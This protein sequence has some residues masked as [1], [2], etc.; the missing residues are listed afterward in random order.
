[1]SEG[2]LVAEI[3]NLIFANLAQNYTLS[4]E[5]QYSKLLPDQDDEIDTRNRIIT[6]KARADLVVSLGDLDFE[7]DITNPEFFIEV[8]RANA[9]KA[10]I[11]ADLRRL[12]EVRQ[13]YPS[14]RAFLFLISEK[15]R[16]KRFVSEEGKSISGKHRVPGVPVSEGHF[17][18][19]RTWKAAHAF[20]NKDNAQYACL[21]E[22]Y[23]RSS[24]GNS[25][26]R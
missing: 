19:R 4:C 10:Q 12:F 2:A 21:V 15:A 24:R 8:K 23:R 25:N 26:R 16:P 5:V 9:P 17:R 22:V 18:K 14:A 20:K 13:K 7:N 6:Q 1:M 3:S 11:D